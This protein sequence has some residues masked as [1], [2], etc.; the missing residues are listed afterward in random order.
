MSNH[1]HLIRTWGKKTKKKTPRFIDR[2]QS[3]K[4][5]LLCDKQ[6]YFQDFHHTF[7]VARDVDGLEHFAVLSTPKLPHELVIVLLAP[8][9]HV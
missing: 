5:S 3:T 9:D 6:T 4:D 8:L 2:P 1:E 7:L